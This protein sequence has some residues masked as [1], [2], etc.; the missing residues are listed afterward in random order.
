MHG[1]VEHQPTKKCNTDPPI[2]AAHCITSTRKGGSGNSCIWFSCA[3]QKF[4]W[5]Q[6]G[7][8]CH[9]TVQS[10]DASMHASVFAELAKKPRP[11]S[12]ADASVKGQ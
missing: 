10:Q 11:W 12:L 9:V 7:A 1:G 6:W 2:S 8:S 4:A 5:S 3:L